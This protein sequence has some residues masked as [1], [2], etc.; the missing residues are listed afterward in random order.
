MKLKNRKNMDIAQDHTALG[1]QVSQ[2]PG[3]PACTVAIL[4]IC[5]PSFSGSVW[6]LSPGTQAGP[7]T[8][9]GSMQKQEPCSLSTE[10]QEFLLLSQR[11]GSSSLPWMA[12]VKVEQ[13]WDG[14]GRSLG[15]LKFSR[16][17]K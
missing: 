8:Q 10:P 4:T 16:L 12:T 13:G 3:F 1:S 5:Q 11:D 6:L 14:D 2:C 9:A 15:V 17:Y 7:S